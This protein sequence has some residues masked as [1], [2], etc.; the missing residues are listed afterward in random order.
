MSARRRERRLPGEWTG[1]PDGTSPAESRSDRGLRNA[2]ES[3]LDVTRAVTRPR[4]SLSD[5][6]D[7]QGG[8]RRVAYSDVGGR[9]D[10]GSR[11][12]DLPG[13]GAVEGR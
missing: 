4:K 5:L 2:A 11:A 8:G 10:N 3:G 12:N 9:S 13:R 6:L 7:L 1:T